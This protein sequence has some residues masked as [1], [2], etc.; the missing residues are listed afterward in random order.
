MSNVKPAEISAILRQQ[1][2][3]FAS[4]AQLEEVGTVLQ[5]GDGIARAYGMDNAQSGE[6]VEFENGLRGIVL[7]LEKTTWVSCF[8]ALQRAS[9]RALR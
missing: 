6:L 1:L 4:E 5:I 8:W 3:G 2:S 9:K 7:N